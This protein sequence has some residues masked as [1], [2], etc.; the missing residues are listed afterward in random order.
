MHVGAARTAR[1]AHT[2]SRGDPARVP[3][4]YY[5]ALEQTAI[6]TRGVGLLLYRGQNGNYGKSKCDY[7]QSGNF[8]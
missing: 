3:T 7:R 8:R 5:S 1:E 4:A 2:C 6:M